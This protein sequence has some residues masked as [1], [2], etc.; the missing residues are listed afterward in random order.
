MMAWMSW[1]S[2][3]ASWRSRHGD[4]VAFGVPGGDASV[5]VVDGGC[6]PAGEADDDGAPQRGV[7]LRVSGVA[8]PTVNWVETG[9]S[10]RRGGRRAE[11]AARTARR[12]NLK[13]EPEPWGEDGPAPGVS[14]YVAVVSW[15]RPTR[16]PID[17]G[18]Q[19]PGSARGL[20]T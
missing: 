10:C 18:T 7:G 8:G 12:L 14:G 6:V 17:R 20:R 4:G 2:W 1:W 16:P 3:R 5:E 15:S 11:L 19:D 9:P 13:T